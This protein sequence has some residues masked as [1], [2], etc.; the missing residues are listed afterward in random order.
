MGVFKQ[1]AIAYEGPVEHHA[2]GPFGES[3]YVKDPSGNFL[4][5]VWRRDESVRYDSVS[6]VGEG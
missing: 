4:E 3:I 2:H 5:F 1:N 6:G